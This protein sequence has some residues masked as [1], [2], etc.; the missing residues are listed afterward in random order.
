ME[1]KGSYF[2][3]GQVFHFQ[4]PL[5]EEGQTSSKKSLF[6]WISTAVG[7]FWGLLVAFTAAYNIQILISGYHS[8]DMKR[9][10]LPVKI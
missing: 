6:F 3:K 8:I 1:G 2:Q 4:I 5:F 9:I 7:R 10:V